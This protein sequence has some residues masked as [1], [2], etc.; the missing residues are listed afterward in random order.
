[1]TRNLFPEGGVL[2]TRSRGNSKYDMSVSIPTDRDGRAAR[3]CPETDCSP[4]YF[5]VKLGTGITGNQV[6]AFCPYC[7]RSGEPSDFTSSEQIRYAKDLVMREAHRGVQGM[8]QNALGLGS[9]GKRSFGGDFIS[10]TMS[11][12]PGSLPSVR[13]P[14]EDEV[15]RDVI[16][17]HCTLDHTVFGLATWCAD[18]GQDIFLSHVDAELKTVTDMVGDVERRRELLGARVAAKDLENCLEDAVSIFEAALKA[19]VRRGLQAKGLSGEEVEARLKKI[20]NSFQSI[21][22]TREQLADA[23]GCALP[24]QVQWEKLSAM[25]EKRHPITHNLGVVDRKYLDKT[26]AGERHGREVRIAGEEV[27]ALLGWV[28]DAISAIHGQLFTG[29]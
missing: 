9:S 3:E 8:L 29:V 26:Q 25:F 11:Y 4:A 22:R 14:Y 21:S 5:K 28:H 1:M 18:C 6:E 16:C 13:L 19:M 10:M 7:R 17:P 2:R 27:H 20:G 15:R 12:K 24:E 23:L